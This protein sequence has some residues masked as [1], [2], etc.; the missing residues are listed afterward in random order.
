VIRLTTLADLTRA[1]AEIRSHGHAIGL[2]PT[3]GALHAG[4]ASL[5]EAARNAGD[6]PV[7][8]VFVNP[9]QFGPGEDLERYPRTPEE[10]ADLAGKAGARVVWSPTVESIYPPGEA[11][12]VRVGPLA[13]VL[14]GACRPGHFDG[15][16][17]VVVKLLA[18]TRPDRLYLGEKDYQQTVVLRQVVR[19]LLLPVTL[20][21]VPTVR[22]PDGL[23]LSSRN[24]FLSPTDRADALRIPEALARAEAMVTEGERCPGVI[25]REM[26]HVLDGAAS[27]RSEYAVV[28]DV[29]L[30]AVEAISGPVRALIAARVGSTRLLDNRLLVP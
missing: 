11:T 16:A 19:D 22:D 15:V 1:L 21:V 5:I 30:Q 28:R 7:V 13:D 24:R 25:E 20:V 26:Q 9:A 18:A 27:L 6:A 2:V 4:H 14:E 17:T 3:M 23:A 8:T 10:D 12:R 29:S